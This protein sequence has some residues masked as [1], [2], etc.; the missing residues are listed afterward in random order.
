MLTLWY[1]NS[2]LEIYPMGMHICV[3]QNTRVKIFIVTLFIIDPIWKLSKCPSI[4]EWINMLSYSYSKRY[5]QQ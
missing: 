1:T 4:A 2:A 3:Y 5:Y